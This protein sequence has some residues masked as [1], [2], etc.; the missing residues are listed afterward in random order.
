VEGCDTGVPGNEVLGDDVLGAD[1]VVGLLKSAGGVL[2]IIWKP[3]N[4]STITTTST[5][6]IVNPL[7]AFVG[8]S[9]VWGV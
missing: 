6:I 3:K 8:V 2:F 9:R 4:A 7:P 5:A 1:V